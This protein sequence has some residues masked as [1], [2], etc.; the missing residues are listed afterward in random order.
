ME[1]D[2]NL[3]WKETD[4]DGY[5]ATIRTSK[6]GRL[7]ARYKQQHFS[8]KDS[9]DGREELINILKDLLKNEQKV[10][11]V[12]EKE[13]SSQISSELEIKDIVPL[14]VDP[15]RYINPD[16]SPD[17]LPVWDINGK[18]DPK[19]SYRIGMF[20]QGK[21]GKTTAMKYL[22]SKIIDQFD[23]VVF[24]SPNQRLDTYDWFK[25]R[26]MSKFKYQVGKGK[27]ERSCF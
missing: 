10:E 8:R 23:L 11:N 16:I 14:Y 24:F 9:K 17:Q 21:A 1:R 20:G 3:V 2:Q 26:F 7:N 6:K 27:K 19:Q 15:K 22:F 4:N 13:E 25:G 18:F 12:E 5:L